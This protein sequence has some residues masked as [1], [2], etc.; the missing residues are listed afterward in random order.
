VYVAT[1]PLSVHNCHGYHQLVFRGLATEECMTSVIIPSQFIMFLTMTSLHHRNAIVIPFP[2]S[3]EL[4]GIDTS[5]VLVLYILYMHP[6][7]P[8]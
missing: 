2:L 5:M 8:E 3:S 6:L 4:Q 1:F 7:R